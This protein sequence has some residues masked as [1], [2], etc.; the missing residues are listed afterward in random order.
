MTA[1]SFR[2]I[3]SG[4]RPG[5]RNMAL[6]QALA[7][8]GAP[9][10]PAVRLYRWSPW[11][12]SLGW[13]QAV[14]AEDLAPWREA[15]F[16]VTRRVTGGGAILHADEV[17]YSVVLPAGDIRIPRETAASYHWLHGAVQAALAE[18]GVA[19]APRGDAE[20]SGGR[21][22][23][24]CFARTAA[25][26]LV[27][28]GRKLVGSAQ[29][30]TAAAFL[31][32]GSIPLSPNGTAPGA[33]SVA[34]ERGGSPIPPEAL[35]EALG[36]AFGAVLG[37]EPVDSAPTPEE[38]ARAA[39]LEAATCGNPAWVLRPW[40]G[41]GR[42]PEPPPAGLAGL[43]SALAPLR[44]LRAAV[45]GG[46]RR[47]GA[48]LGGGPP[49]LPHGRLLS[50]GAAL[51]PRA[52]AR[53]LTLERDPWDSTFRRSAFPDAPGAHGPEGAGV[54]R[55][56]VEEESVAVLLLYGSPFEA[57]LLEPRRLH[58]GD[59]GPRRAGDPLADARTLL[60]DLLARAPRAAADAGLR[61][62]LSGGM[63]ARAPGEGALAALT[64]AAAL[65]PSTPGPLK[66]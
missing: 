51:L 41:R 56:A 23:F 28:S 10:E 38:E 34:E 64:V 39:A 1:K 40:K 35:E 15:G 9:P 46:G 30:R 18:V 24:F 54:R 29:R 27:A 52:S 25:I 58:F 42:A 45:A 17:T 21:D 4:P 61:A 63:P 8:E 2:L 66:S 32:H 22:P 26:D 12:L 16:D 49:F 36:R 65:S 6:D 19:A 33:T 53:P 5:P 50:A 31:Q 20:A 47:V 3:R 55:L 7:G 43:P 14:A 13:F 60:A 62:L 59:L 57:L 37:A 11:T 44:V 48:S